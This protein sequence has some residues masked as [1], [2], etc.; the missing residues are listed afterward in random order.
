[1]F[2]PEFP[3]EACTATQRNLP[4][5]SHGSADFRRAT[6]KQ[7]IKECDLESSDPDCS[8]MLYCRQNQAGDLV[9]G[10][11]A[12][13]LSLQLCLDKGCRLTPLMQAWLLAMVC[14]HAA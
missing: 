8:G 7:T 11:S 14:L 13:P 3:Q 12:S 2:N 4:S 10:P 5:A 6:F 1:M 9:P